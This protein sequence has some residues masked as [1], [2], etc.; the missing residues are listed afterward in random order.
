MFVVEALHV[1][2]VAGDE[3]DR[4]EEHGEREGIDRRQGLRHE[5]PLNLAGQA[6]RPGKL[7][8]HAAL[9][10]G[11]RVAGTRQRATHVEHSAQPGGELADVEGAAER[12]GQARRVWEPCDRLT[13]GPQDE[14]RPG[15]GAQARE[16]RAQIGRDGG[17]IRRHD[18]D[19]GVDGVGRAAV[20][21]I[22]KRAEA[23]D[24][25][26][27][28]Q[29]HLKGGGQ[30]VAGED[31]LHMGL[32]HGVVRLRGA[33]WRGKRAVHHLHRPETRATWR[34][35]AWPGAESRRMRPGRQVAA[36]R[37]GRCWAAF[38]SENGAN[39]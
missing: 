17:L 2:D 7:R 33:P 36:G 4:T 22:G 31:D 5:L 10:G 15:R 32:R 30:D 35:T 8:G 39:G 6:Q 9:H 25:P 26:S 29:G 28:A 27:A 20:D 13:V 16:E 18:D 14:R 38:T 1:E 19:V 24:G 11:L 23:R 12:D 34:G 21:R 3:V 37:T